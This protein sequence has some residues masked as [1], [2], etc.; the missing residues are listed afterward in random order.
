[1]VFYDGIYSNVLDF[2]FIIRERYM[3]WLKY[4]F[5]YHWGIRI[6]WTT[7]TRSKKVRKVWS[8]E[9]IP[10]IKFLISSHGNRKTGKT[11]QVNNDINRH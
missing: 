4:N 11:F 6:E 9:T 10:S 7:F 1:M 3:T 5:E 8:Y 2:N